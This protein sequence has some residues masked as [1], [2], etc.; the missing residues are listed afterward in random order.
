MEKLTFDSFTRKIY[1]KA[2]I[3]KIY[4]LWATKGGIES[5]FLRN[6]EFVSDEGKTRATT[7]FV[8]VG[9]R[10][11]WKWHNWDGQEAGEVLQANG[12]NYIEFSFA[13]VSKVS[14]TLEDKGNAVLLTLKQFE[15]P[16][17][18]E[19]K[20]NIYNGCSNGWT[21]WLANLKAFLEHGILLNETEFDLTKIPLAGHVYVNM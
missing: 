16:L 21:F 4:G 11:V 2:S 1:I 7:E 18:E 3:E 14:V 15:I 20:M 12:S 5:W 13:E 17:D 19:S 8:Q 10:Y 6:A 9:D